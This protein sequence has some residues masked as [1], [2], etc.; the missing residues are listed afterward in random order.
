MTQRDTAGAF[1]P[2]RC[3]QVGTADVRATRADRARVVFSTA[4]EARSERTSSRSWRTRRA[5]IQAR[6]GGPRPSIRRQST[7]LPLRNSA[8]LAISLIAI[9]ATAARAADVPLAPLI[10]PKSA[11]T[12]D[13]P[14]LSVVGTISPTWTD[15]AL[16]S[17]DNRLS[18]FYLEP[19]ISVRLDGRFT[20]DLAWRVYARSEFD[21]FAKVRDADEAFAL[22]GGRLTQSIADWRVS[23]IYENR[24]VYAGVFREL[25]F[26]AHDVKGAIARTFN[27]DNWTLSPLVQIR[28]R[29]ADLPEPRH[30]RLDLLLG[31]EYRLDQKWSIVS[32]PF[33][34][35]YWFTDGLN[36]G[37]RDWIYSASLGLKYNITDSVSLTGN[38]A[39]EARTSNVPLRHYQS[40]DIGPRLDFA[41]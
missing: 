19:D 9:G 35:G 26:V 6:K 15:N 21:R 22:V 5:L 27:V 18:D 38:V 12:L 1:L 7:E 11:P 3:Q 16:F 28:Y 25:A 4:R 33:I 37:R 34:E 23:L 24:Y 10:A 39:Y 41:F 2:E 8:L 29:F 36:T 40:W 31:I 17:R 20:P 13:A 30:Y 32:T 14:T